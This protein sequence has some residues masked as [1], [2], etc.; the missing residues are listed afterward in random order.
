MFVVFADQASTA[1]M[2]LIAYAY[3]LQKDCYSAKSKSAKTFQTVYLAAIWDCPKLGF[4]LRPY[5]TF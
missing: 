1:N 5:M 4:L 3:M 2:N